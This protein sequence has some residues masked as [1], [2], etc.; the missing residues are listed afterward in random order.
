MPAPLSAIPGVTDLLDKLRHA[1]DLHAMTGT[2]A[3][4]QDFDVAV[5]HAASAGIPVPEILRATR[6]SEI[7]FE[8]AVARGKFFAEAGRI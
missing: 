3:S 7:H 5:Y 4:R 6:L 1:Q 8:I 2:L